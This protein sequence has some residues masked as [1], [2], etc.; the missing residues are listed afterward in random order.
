MTNDELNYALSRFVREIKKQS[1]EEFPGKT[2]RELTLA[3][4]M[5]LEKNG[6]VVKLLCDPAFSELKN[7][8]DN[9]MK[10]R[11]KQGIGMKIKQAQE[12][13]LEEEETLWQKGIL[14]SDTP[15]QLLRTLFYLVGVHF[16]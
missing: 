7:T 15:K 16:A 9:M 3:I 13:T 10:K 6:K 11:A 1:G 5:S 4:Q 12:I 2:L 8:L 14:G